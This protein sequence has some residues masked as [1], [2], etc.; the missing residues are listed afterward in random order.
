MDNEN[1][2]VGFEKKTNKLL[3]RITVAIVV[4]FFIFCYIKILPNYSTFIVAVIITPVLILLQHR[5]YSPKIIKLILTFEIIIQ[6]VD[7]MFMFPNVAFVLPVVGICFISMYLDK[8]LILINYIIF[9]SILVY[10]Q[11]LK[12]TLDFKSL[13]VCLCS[14]LFAAL[15]L[16]SVTDLGKKLIVESNAEKVH[17]NK[18][19]A[20]IQNTINTVEV[21]TSELN[22][23]INECNTNLAFVQEGSTG[24]T[25]TVEQ[26]TK[27]V[28]EQAESTSQINELITEANLKIL[29]V[30]NYSKQLSDVSK[31][32]STVVSNGSENIIKMSN[33]MSIIKRSVT[34]SLDTVQELDKN[35]NEVN[36]FLSG[37]TQI[38]VQTNLLALNAA[39]E[40]A[41]AGE[42]GK[43]FSVVA[44]E[45]RKLS[46]ET[47]ATVKLIDE[48][49]KD[50][51]I[52]TKNVVISA[53]NG[54]VA[55]NEGE[56]FVIEVN[57]GFKKIQD[58]F[59]DIDSNIACELKMIEETSDLFSKIQGES[60][61]IAAISEEQSASNE[62][63][64]ATIEEQN[65]SIDNISVSM[66]SIKKASENLKENIKNNR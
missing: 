61:G 44:D 1:V 23:D 12:S 37:I 25:F 20:E 28:V 59:K 51:R 58:S 47:G 4:T 50:I 10:I 24:I 16:Y 19:L 21:N 11:F 35:M 22:N 26:L 57:K 18:L 46:E 33:H 34:Q 45:V 66:S 17:A 3:I 42:A 13:I 30:L 43:G 62:E 54:S 56:V 64:L 9:T 55:T 53:Q 5:G 39:I 63:M 32:T 60:S 40:A 8:W 41:R 48:V 7:I 52:K 49:M 27:G 15:V 14:S 29:E 2:L 31:T 38:A 6:V 65:S 36:K